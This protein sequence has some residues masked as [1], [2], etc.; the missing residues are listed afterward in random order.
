MYVKKT[1]THLN[2]ETK[3][4]RVDNINLFN[5][6]HINVVQARCSV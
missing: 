2:E 1:C 4:Q 5:Y 3:K 6:H